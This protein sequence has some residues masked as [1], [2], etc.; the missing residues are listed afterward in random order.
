MATATTRLLDAIRAFNGNCT[1]Y[2][3]G[4]LLGMTTA[5]VSRWRTGVGHMSMA[6]V[7][8]ACELAGVDADT[9][10]WQIRIGAEREKGPDGD[11]YREALKDLESYRT[12][13]EPSPNGLFALLRKGGRA[14]A[15]VAFLLLGLIGALFP[16][17]QASAA[18]QA[19]TASEPRSIDYTNYGRRRRR[20]GDFGKNCLKRLFHGLFVFP[21]TPR[22]YA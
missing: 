5:T 7:S 19:I 9:W 6:N 11:I 21:A 20:L 13:G 2:R 17:K 16:E 10:E 22:S 18:M 12:S 15:M 14:A 8:R 1:D 4:K 3:A